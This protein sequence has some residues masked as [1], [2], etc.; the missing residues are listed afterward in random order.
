MQTEL[1]F[2]RMNLLKSVCII[3]IYEN[4]DNLVV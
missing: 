1:S 3:F 2:I 4:S